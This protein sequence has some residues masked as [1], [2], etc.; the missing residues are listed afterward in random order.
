MREASGREGRGQSAVD[1]A[2]KRSMAT[3]VVVGDGGCLFPEK[4]TGD[5]M[6]MR[7]L[8]WLAGWMQG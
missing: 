6:K 5:E 8:D 3:W 1:G 4:A 2:V 7:V